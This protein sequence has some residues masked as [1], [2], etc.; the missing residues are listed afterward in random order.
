MRQV[1]LGF[2]VA[3]LCGF[4]ALTALAAN[5]DGTWEGTVEGRRGPQQVTFTLKA[6]GGKLMGKVSNRRGDSDIV[7]GK[8][9]GDK[10]SFKQKV[11]FQDRDI[12]FLYTGT[13]MGDQ[14]KMTRQVEGSGEPRE[15]TAKRKM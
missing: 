8:V 15:F 7:D 12:T 4:G 14:I 10:I 5:V 13:V 6:E 3:A 1:F 2:L 9:E 11:T